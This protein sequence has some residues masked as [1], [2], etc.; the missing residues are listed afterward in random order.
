MEEAVFYIQGLPE[1]KSEPLASAASIHSGQHVA[2]F[3]AGAPRHGAALS[4]IGPNERLFVAGASAIIFSYLWGKESVDQRF[5]VPEQMACLAVANH[6]ETVSDKSNVTSPSSS[7]LSAPACPWLL[8]AGAPSG[9]LYVWELASGRLLCVKDAHYQALTMIQ[10]SRCGTFA[11]TAGEDARV[12]VWRTS[13]LVTGTAA[14]FATFADHTLAVTD[15]CVDSGSL[16]VV[17]ASRDG[18]VRVYDIMS[19][20]LRSTFVFSQP[21]SSVARDPAGRALY[22][23][24]ADGT[25]RQVQMYTVNPHTHMMEAVGSGIVTVPAD[26]ELA[27]TFVHHGSAEVTSLAMSMDGINLVS[28]DSEGR[29]FVTD[30][31]TKQVVRA[32]TA[33]A[34]VSHLEVGVFSREKKA[35]PA[36]MLIPLKRVVAAQDPL[37]H[38]VAVQIR[39]DEHGS[40]A[41]KSAPDFAAWLEEKAHQ[42]WEFAQEAPEQQKLQKLSAAYNA[43]KE[44]YEKLLAGKEEN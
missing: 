33:G 14:P 3:R 26:P 29:V 24:L 44:N 19:K 34:S 1:K 27:Y 31:V 15:I 40:A 6:P 9:R 21:V 17:S 13:D 10:F 5:P 42:Q 25:I 11:V 38:S 37:E 43:L 16:S 35:A 30:V 32:F 2:S 39:A 20:T 4:G 22:A 36:R 41:A 8:A 12:S 7:P 28:G 18:T 23:A